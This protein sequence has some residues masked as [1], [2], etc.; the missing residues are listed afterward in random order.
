MIRR[1]VSHIQDRQWELLAV[2]IAV[3]AWYRLFDTRSFG[4]A[5]AAALLATFGW[6]AW[7]YLG[8]RAFEH[9]RPGRAM[10]IAVVLWAIALYDFYVGDWLIALLV[11]VIAA[12]HAHAAWTK[13]TLQEADDDPET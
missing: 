1:Y 8:K 4:L 12:V 11:L 9:P 5:L 10:F 13:Q 6:S 2:M 7:G 3:F